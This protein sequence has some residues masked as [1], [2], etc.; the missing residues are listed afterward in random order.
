MYAYPRP[1]SH[2]HRPTYRELYLST[3][4]WDHPPPPTVPQPPLRTADVQQKPGKNYWCWLCP[5]CE[6]MMYEYE[7]PV[8][9]EMGVVVE[10]P[11]CT[12]DTVVGEKKGEEEDKEEK[13]EKESRG[14]EVEPKKSE[15]EA[16]VADVAEAGN[17]PVGDGELKEAK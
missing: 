3:M 17:K 9:P 6:E 4:I 5:Y 10:C 14:E 16:A 11:N 12:E 13:E 2:R 1:H 7:K 15:P 8:P